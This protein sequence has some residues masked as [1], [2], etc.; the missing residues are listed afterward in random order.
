MKLLFSLSFYN[1]T[2]CLLFK[3]GFFLTRTAVPSTIYPIIWLTNGSSE[4][5]AKTQNLIAGA[6]PLPS[7]HLNEQVIKANASGPKSQSFGTRCKLC[8]YFTINW[9]QLETGLVCTVAN[10]CCFN[11]LSD[12]F[13]YFFSFT[14]LRFAV[15][16][17]RQSALKY[18]FSTNSHHEWY[19]IN[20]WLMKDDI[21]RQTLPR[22][23]KCE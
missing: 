20:R 19:L 2:H 15:V 8:N 12:N 9:L 5:S 14:V 17:R 7:M 18:S 22:Q 13:K 6:A 4:G 10:P 16:I 1:T 11:T 23:K 21:L 3:R